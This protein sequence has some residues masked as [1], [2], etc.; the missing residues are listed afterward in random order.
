MTQRFDAAATIAV[1]DVLER[2]GVEYYIG[3]SVASSAYGEYRTTADVDIVAA[4]KPEHVDEFVRS[5]QNEYYIDAAM[6][7]DAMRH[8][9]SFNLIH[10]A[11]M[12]K[13]DIFLPSTRPYD[14]QAWSRRRSETPFEDL[15]RKFPLAS[16]EDTILKKLEWY[17]IGGETSQRQ[18]DDIVKMM[19]V[20][21]NNL[22]WQYLSRWADELNVRDLLERA[23]TEAEAL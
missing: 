13:V 7:R 16:I 1:A 6:I 3:G 17:R 23:K 4:L 15:D 12:Y 19:R 14:V 20:Q 8:R 10:L 2:L 5:L 9:S 21:L 22:D 11:T 18:I